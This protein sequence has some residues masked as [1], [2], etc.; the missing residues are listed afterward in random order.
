M[1]NLT[2]TLVGAALGQAGLKRRSGLAMPALM[3]AANIP[4]VDIVCALAGQ[5][6]SGRRGWT[7]GPVGLVVL[8]LLLT[9]A[10]I[11]FDRRQ[12]RRGTRPDARPVVRPGALLA[13]SY[14]GALSHPLLDLM[15]NWGIRLLMPFSERWFY[16]DTL[17]IADPWIWSCLAV[18]IWL[19]R[20]REAGG[21]SAVAVPAGVSLAITILYSAAMSAG[22]RVAEARAADAFHARHGEDPQRVLASPVF[23]DPFRRQ[24]IIQSGDRY[25]FG[26]VNF[27]ARTQ[28]SLGTP[29]ATGLS[30]PAV[31]DAQK[32]DSA[33]ADF[34]YWSRFP[35]AD[36]RRALGAAIVHLGDAR[37]GQKPGSG[38]IGA[39]V[40]IP[41]RLDRGGD[42]TSPK[43]R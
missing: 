1:D 15:N 3:I 8:P 18:G 40:T 17:F 33:A 23:A 14:V 35:I 28:V 36:V 11:L 37:F 5:G 4:E 29:L 24:I 26:E 6:L 20:R 38:P 21:R 30:D 7:H 16:G 42:A 43:P 25:V 32:Q 31:A 12:A 13:I 39:V 19:S 9:G 22:G 2:H 10:L 34:L 27:L 41:D